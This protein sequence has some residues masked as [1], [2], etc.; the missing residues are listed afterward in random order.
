M[1]G[2]PFARRDLLQAAIL[3]A[4]AG[5]TAAAMPNRSGIAAAIPDLNH[6]VPETI[7]RWRHHSASGVIL[8]PPDELSERI[9]DGV[10]AR[11][12]VAA[13]APPVMLLIAYGAMQDH[14]RRLHR[15]EGC[16][17][18]AGY[19]LGDMATARLALPGGREIPAIALA[20][21]RDGRHERLLYWTRIGAEYPTDEWRERIAILRASLGGRTVDGVLVRLSTPLADAATAMPV[22][23]AFHSAL[24]ASLDPKGRHLLLGPE[25]A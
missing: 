21:Q 10:L 25:E 12:Y 6:I 9:Y 5:I 14:E 22:L 1:T 4:T 8:P 3:V 24:L 23:R 13:D 11:A 2:A 20:A 18:A 17:P 19:T 15:P 7:G 16:Y